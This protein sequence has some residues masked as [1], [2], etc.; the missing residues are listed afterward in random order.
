MRIRFRDSRLAK[1]CNDSKL[2]V[3]RYGP[4]GGKLIRRRLDE[5]AAAET[6]ADL[7]TLRQVRCHELKA[8]RRGQLSVDLKHPQRLLFVPDDDPIPR[9]KDGGL[10]W[11][12][13]KAVLILGVEDTH[14]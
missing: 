14:G 6:L 9:R 4:E 10:D 7:R 2:L 1:E 11:S 12:G 8:D 3:R 5:L 13:V